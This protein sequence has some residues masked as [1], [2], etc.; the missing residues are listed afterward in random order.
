[1]IAEIEASNQLILSAQKHLVFGP[2][3]VLKNAI[4]SPKLKALSTILH[5]TSQGCTWFEI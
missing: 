4:I 2:I 1:M 3:F 5:V